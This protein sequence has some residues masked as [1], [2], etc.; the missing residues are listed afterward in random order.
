[1]VYTNTLMS[2]LIGIVL[3]KCILAKLS[4]DTKGSPLPFDT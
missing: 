1:M 4:L 2:N 3:I